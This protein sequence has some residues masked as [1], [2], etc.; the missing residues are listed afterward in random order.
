M[1]NSED[2]NAKCVV[3]LKSFLDNFEREYLKENKQRQQLYMN[4]ANLFE[5]KL[6]QDMLQKDK[7]KK[8]K[9]SKYKNYLNKQKI[10][11][12]NNPNK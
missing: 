5:E 11:N 10:L 3:N 8:K 6:N 1:K 7:E 12:Q 2:I 4:N 9:N